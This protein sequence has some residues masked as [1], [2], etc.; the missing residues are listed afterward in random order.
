MT[1]DAFW[2]RFEKTD[3]KDY[4]ILHEILPIEKL[5]SLMERSDPADTKDSDHYALYNFLASFFRDA[6][7]YG[8]ESKEDAG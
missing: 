3:T 5:K 4:Q 6:I 2:S 7:E 8:R 1:G